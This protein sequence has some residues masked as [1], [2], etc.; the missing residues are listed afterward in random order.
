MSNYNNQTMVNSTTPTNQSTSTNSILVDPGPIYNS[1]TVGYFFIGFLITI[2]SSILNAFG[3]NL[4]KLDLNKQLKSVTQNRQKSCCRP[5]WLLG[6]SLYILSQVLGSTLALQYMRSEYVAPLG[7]TSLIFNFLFARWLLGT[8]ITALDAVGTL[9]VIL[10]VV[11]VIGFGNIRQAGI[12]EEAN[13]SLSTLEALWARPAWIAHLVLLEMITAMVLWLANIGYEVIEEKH[14]FE[15]SRVLRDEE[16]TDVEMVLRRGGGRKSRSGFMER[17]FSFLSPLLSLQQRLR[18]WLKVSIE[19][20]SMS[21]SDQSMMK[22]DGLLWGCSAGLLAG[23]T[24]IFAKSY[25]K[26][27]SNGL[28]HQRGEPKD[29]AH[30]LSIL[31]LILLVLTGVLQ[32]WCLNRGLKVYD[33]T[34]IVPVLFATYTGSGF[35]NSLI[36]LHELPNYRTSVLLMIW[37]CIGVLVIGVCMLSA[38]RVEGAGPKAKPIGEYSSSAD[39][40]GE[41][42]QT[43]IGREEA[44]GMVM[45]N[46]ERPIK[47]RRSPSSVG[48]H[49]PE[50]LSESSYGGHRRQSSEDS[51]VPS[52]V[53]LKSQYPLNPSGDHSR[54]LRRSGLSALPNNPTDNPF[55]DFEIL[56]NEQLP[57]ER[58]QTLLSSGED[59]ID[60]LQ[61]SSDG[62]FRPP[63]KADHHDRFS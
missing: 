1:Y 12:D 11:G 19:R 43:A 8:K 31:I 35:I 45:I 54:S 49:Q 14:K 9:V 55:D 32:V 50:Q 18:T 47:K 57:E 42:Q 28:D 48:H 7:S 26:L 23:Q 59:E 27:V 20:W 4:Q 53:E 37:L 62:Y 10:G 38:K 24:L 40:E 61:D 39:P 3:I 22:L 13:M 58:D 36:Y 41:A 44:V 21:R 51:S 33:S 2:T 17:T 34:L 16:D 46:A 15:A 60:G 52:V 29:L 30:P 56:D 6:L 63:D 25:V 5:I